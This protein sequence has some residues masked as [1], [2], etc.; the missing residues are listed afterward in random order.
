MR[1]IYPEIPT[2][3]LL[4]CLHWKNVV[5][6]P[7]SLVSVVFEPWSLVSAHHKTYLLWNSLKLRNLKTKV[8][9]LA[10]E[11]LWCS[12]IDCMVKL[13]RSAFLY[14]KKKL[15]PFCK[16][17]ENMKP[18]KVGSCYTVNQLR[19]GLIMLVC[20]NHW[21]YA[22]IVNTFILKKYIF[23]LDLWG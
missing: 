12:C 16:S 13:C 7:W 14:K 10:A 4:A 18:R 9:Y 20:L 1:H 17:L 22:I 5:F 2:S 23:V 6:E 3:K 19:Q 21:G 15:A 8:L 11:F